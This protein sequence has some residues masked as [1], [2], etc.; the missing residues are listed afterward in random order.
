MRHIRSMIAGG[1]FA[2]L[3]LSSLFASVPIFQEPP[4][5]NIYLDGGFREDW[6]KFHIGGNHCHPKNFSQVEWR[7]LKIAQIS[8][9]INYS[10]CH[11]YYMRANGSYGRVVDGSGSVSNEWTVPHQPAPHDHHHKR[12]HDPHHSDY[13]REHHHQHHHEHHY[14]HQRHH[15]HYRQ[16]YSKQS[17]DADRGYVCDASGGLGFKVISG[18]GRGWVAGLIGYSYDRQSLKMTNFKQKRDTLNQIVPEALNGV[19]GSYKTRWTGPFVGID[20]SGKVECDVTIFGSAEWHVCDFRGEGVWQRH[21]AYKAKIRHHARGYGAVGTLGFDW[22]P[23]DHWGFGLIANYQQWST[24][25][26]NNHSSTKSLLFPS[27][28]LPLSFPVAQ[29]SRLYRVKWISY[30]LS[31]AT[32]YRF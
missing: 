26:G 17:A 28:Q 13:S 19:R 8:G 32:T 12:H 3:Q 11:H 29:K 5:L 30:S 4:P 25:K 31:F 23:F 9:G 6:L 14:G 2:V 21:P 20:F 15:P 1:T 27:S 22:A 16:E 7:N 18:G 10:T 24:R